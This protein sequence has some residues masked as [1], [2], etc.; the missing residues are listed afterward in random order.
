MNADEEII[1][2]MN[3]H[4]TMTYDKGSRKGMDLRAEAKLLYQAI[5]GKFQY[6]CSRGDSGYLVD[7]IVELL[8][9]F[10][11]HGEI[12]EKIDDFI[13]LIQQFK[14]FIERFIPYFVSGKKKAT[15]NEVEKKQWVHMFNFF[16]RDYV[17]VLEDDFL[18]K[19]LLFEDIISYGL[20]EPPKDMKKGDSLDKEIWQKLDSKRVSVREMDPKGNDKR[21]KKTVNNAM[22]VQMKKLFQ[23]IFAC[24]SAML[25]PAG[26][27]G[28]CSGVKF[29]TN[30]YTLEYKISAKGDRSRNYIYIKLPIKAINDVSIVDGE[31]RVVINGV[32]LVKD[33]FT[34]SHFNSKEPFSI[35]SI[36]RRLKPF[37][38]DYE[39]NEVR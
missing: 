22:P 10:E 28:S 30:G 27:F 7:K 18:D 19:A 34:E 24:Q 23:F 31:I 14:K 39:G 38:G 9:I 17:D 13:Q 29:S 3:T 36:V 6:F 8:K 11:N 21:D 32:D 37:N 5:E 16:T 35:A 2:E 26:K 20:E 15:L 25:D 4:I 33:T 1:P 12:L